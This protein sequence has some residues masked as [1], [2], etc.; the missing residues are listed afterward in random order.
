MI[1]HMRSKH[2]TLVPQDT[3]LRRKRDAE[4]SES[5]PRKIDAKLT[6][7]WALQICLAALQPVSSISDEHFRDVLASRLPGLPNKTRL[8]AE[9]DVVVKA[10]VANTWNFFSGFDRDEFC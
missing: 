10:C 2:S 7:D 1:N 5:A 9:V 6:R 4:H 3:Q 8:A